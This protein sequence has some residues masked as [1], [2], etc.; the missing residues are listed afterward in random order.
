MTRPQQKKR[1]LPA[2]FG[3]AID[4]DSG[5]REDAHTHQ[6]A[7]L[8]YAVSGLIRVRTPSASWIVAPNCALLVPPR[9]AHELE[10]IGAVQFRT[11]YLEPCPVAGDTEGRLLPVNAL[12]RESIQLMVTEP[13]EVPVPGSRADLVGRLIMTLLGEASTGEGRDDSLERW[14]GNVPMPQH[15][16]LR[17]ICQTIAQ[18]PGNSASLEHWGSRLGASART[19]ARLFQSETGMAFSKWREQLRVSEAMCRLAA[20]DPIAEVATRLGYGDINTFA[21]MFKRVLHMTP[22]KYQAMM[23]PSERSVRRP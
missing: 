3:Q 16:R 5:T 8:L 11:L 17:K 13:C 18:D 4:Y 9:V 6:R 12:L 15:P 14:S 1:T 10:M 22:Q 7:Q 23:A 19:L 21:V 2:V 20:N